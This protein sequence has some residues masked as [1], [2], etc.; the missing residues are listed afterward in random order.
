M[1][2]LALP[3][4]FSKQIRQGRKK[5]HYSCYAYGTFRSGKH[6]L[7][8]GSVAGWFSLTQY[9]RITANRSEEEVND[10]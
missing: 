9:D 8:I 3:L 4:W 7:G 5:Q 10:S 2:Q 6:K 1:Q